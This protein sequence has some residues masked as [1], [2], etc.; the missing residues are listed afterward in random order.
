MEKEREIL[1][2]EFKERR[3]G[4]GRGL[5]EPQPLDNLIAVSG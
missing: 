2:R 3:M 1:E 5:S 4:L